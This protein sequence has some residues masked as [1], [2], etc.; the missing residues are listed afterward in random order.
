[1]LAGTRRRVLTHSL[2]ESAKGTYR[3]STRR[4]KAK[5]E[6]DPEAWKNG[7]PNRDAPD[8]SR[9]RPATFAGRKAGRRIHAARIQSLAVTMDKVRRVLPCT[10]GAAAEGAGDVAAAARLLNDES[11][12]HLVAYAAARR[13][14]RG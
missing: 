3:R 4:E 10:P 14:E 1:M 8:G 9:G 11:A 7:S 13:R 2:Y 5:Y 12:A 6:T